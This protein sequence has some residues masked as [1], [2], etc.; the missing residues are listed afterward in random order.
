M[1][2]PIIQLPELTLDWKQTLGGPRHNLVCTRTHKKAVVTPEEID[3]DLLRS[4]LESPVEA[5]VGGGLL[6]GWG[7]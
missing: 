3:P 1:I 7:H 4:V 6:Q 2:N 5:W